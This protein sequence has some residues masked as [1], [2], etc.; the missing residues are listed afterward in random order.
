MT[1]EDEEQRDN[2][3]GELLYVGRCL[4]E[5]VLVGDRQRIQFRV[6]QI[7]N[8]IWP[9]IVDISLAPWEE[10]KFA[11][12]DTEKQL[13]ESLKRYVAVLLFFAG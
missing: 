12:P 9:Q 2:L 6:N 10:G 8:E 4:K 5:A 1:T 3:I 11:G 7:K 13:Q